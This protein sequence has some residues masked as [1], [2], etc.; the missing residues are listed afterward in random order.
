LRQV[1]RRTS[2]ARVVP[3]SETARTFVITIHQGSP[4]LI[5]SLVIRET[6]G[7]TVAREVSGADCT[8][9]AGVLALAT[10]LAIDPNAALAP[11]GDAAEPAPVPEAPPPR[12]ALPEPTPSRP[13]PLEEPGDFSYG[14]SLGPAIEGMVAP[15]LA[16][17]ATASLRAFRPSRLPFPSY[18]VDFTALGALTSSLREAR[19]SHQFYFARPDA[20]L[21]S[22]RPSDALALMPCAGA[23]IGV[24]V[25]RGE[26]V[27]VGATRSRLWA[28]ADFI[29]RLHA[30]VS[31]RWF[32]DLDGSLVLPIT[33]Y[34][35]V[36]RD[37]DTPV[38]TVPP[39]AGAGSAR[40][41]YNF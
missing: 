5:G 10:A 30:V 1:F 29:L 35:F 3:E 13:R 33:R 16:I 25:A 11:V 36:F 8:D 27:A 6:N 4:G 23:E 22:L 17:G 28:T 12:P 39:I 40:V 37:P 24:V 19:V 14:M 15:R 18:G 32:V 2:S 21:I 7:T 9:V 34:V 20:C 31:D 26:N 38:H 41:G